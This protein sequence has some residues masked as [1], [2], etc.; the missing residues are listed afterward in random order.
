LSNRRSS[1][2]RVAE[3]TFRS[4]I[5]ARYRCPS[6]RVCATLQVVSHWAAPEKRISQ[7]G[8]GLAER[9]PILA[10]YCC[11]LR[12]TTGESPLLWAYARTSRLNV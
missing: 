8:R 5:S 6:R 3:V 12:S 4:D 2:A 10:G 1:W 7:E 11:G 9:A